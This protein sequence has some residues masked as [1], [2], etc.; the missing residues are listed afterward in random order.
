MYNAAQHHLVPELTVKT[1][2]NDH[3]SILSKNSCDYPFNHHCAALMDND[4]FGSCAV[5]HY[6]LEVVKMEWDITDNIMN[7]HCGPCPP[8]ISSHARTVPQGTKS[9]S[10]F[11]VLFAALLH[12]LYNLLLCFCLSSIQHGFDELMEH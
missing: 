11:I 10:H 9:D 1:V 4:D 7:W 5:A 12:A 6:T 8:L 2:I 3:D